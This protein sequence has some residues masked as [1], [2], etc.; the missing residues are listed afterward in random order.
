MSSNNN[1][2]NIHKNNIDCINKC[3][4]SKYKV[5]ILYDKSNEQF[6][7]HVVTKNISLIDYI[8]LWYFNKNLN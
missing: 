7:T 3:V 6:F 1:N 4:T 5:Y 2:S 8:Y